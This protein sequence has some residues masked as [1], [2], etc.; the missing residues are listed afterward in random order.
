M[1]LLIIMVFTL[2]QNSI[3]HVH[4]VLERCSTKNENT[5]K[6]GEECHCFGHGPQAHYCS[7]PYETI[8]AKMLL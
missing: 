3:Y 4:A 7:T 8:L 2:D 6:R 5:K 1:L